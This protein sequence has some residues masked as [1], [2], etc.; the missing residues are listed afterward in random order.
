MSVTDQSIVIAAEILKRGGIGAFPTET[1]YGLAADATN[2]EA[3][4]RVF[5]AKGR[6]TTNPVIVHVGS[7]QF[8]REWVAEWPA[9]AQ[10][11]AERFWPGPLTL[12]LPRDPRLAAAVT[13]GGET[14][15]VRMPDHPVAL[16][17][18]RA[19][20]LPLIGPSANR[21]NRV[22]PTTANDVRDELEDRI[23][24]ILN[25]GPCRVG[26]ESTVLDLSRLRPRV[27]RPGAVSMEALREV[28]GDVDYQ[29]TVSSEHIAATSP[30]QFERHYSPRTPTYRFE[31]DDA[32]KAK[33]LTARSG[34]LRLQLP[35]DPFLCA[36]Q[37]YQSLR[38]ADRQ[39]PE[40][41][42]IEMPPSEPQWLAVRD[43]LSRAA[44]PI[45][46]AIGR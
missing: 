10:A 16:D 42:L 29:S 17:L 32:Q 11:L 14:V 8:G 38:D 19:A 4:D 5:R 23:D 9:R 30:G 3:V 22:S 34:V 39:N 27:L 44:R 37:L 36:R 28:V 13:A 33:Q 21:S 12:V 20:D 35:D 24:F 15:G 26:I 40:M 46:E 31:S 1:V 25:G 7:I 2:V 43:R 18:L 41:I 45:A 6:P